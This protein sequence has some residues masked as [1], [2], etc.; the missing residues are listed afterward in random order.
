M[1]AAAE[2]SDEIEI[3]APQYP[4]TIY[5]RLGRQIT[6]NSYEKFKITKAERPLQ[7][8]KGYKYAKGN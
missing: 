6:P 1:A 7:L 8:W 4:G 3:I 5:T 2:V